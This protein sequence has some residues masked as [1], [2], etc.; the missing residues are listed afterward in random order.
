MRKGA[1]GRQGR[2][3][4]TSSL[5]SGGNEEADVFAPVAARLPLLPGRVPEGLPLGGEVAVTGRDAEEEGVVF[6]ELV[7]RDEGDGGG[8]AGGV[9]LGEDLL[10]E[11]LLNSL[12]R[13][14]EQVSFNDAWC[15]QRALGM[16]RGSISSRLKRKWGGGPTGKRRRCPRRPQCRPSQLRRAWQYDRTW[17]TM[18]ID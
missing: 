7:G 5:G 10:R 13:G 11:G 12:V 18:S 2:A 3:L 17:N 4:L 6:G 14:R 1:H 16:S 8:L 9:H 15:D